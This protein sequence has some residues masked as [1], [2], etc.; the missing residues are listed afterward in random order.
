MT[1]ATAH[2]AIERNTATISAIYDAFGR[3]DVAAILAHISEDVDWD[4][5]YSPE[6]PIP[7]LQR[8]SGSAHAERFFSTLMHHLDIHRF[9]IDRVLAGDDVAVVLFSIDCTVRATGKRIV[10]QDEPHIWHFNDAGKVVRF[11]HAADTLQQF[12]A[13]QP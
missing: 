6:F 4:Y 1:T 10:E 3:G 2:E 12:Q 7:W 11:R 8:G 9:A 13:V 5:A